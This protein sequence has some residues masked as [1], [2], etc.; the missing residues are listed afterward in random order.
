M[1]RS[2]LRDQ[3]LATGLPIV[4]DTRTQLNLLAKNR[5]HSLQCPVYYRLGCKS[6]KR[7]LRIAP[8]IIGVILNSSSLCQGY[9]GTTAYYGNRGS[10]RLAFQ[11]APING[12]LD[13]LKSDPPALGLCHP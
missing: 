2:E 11:A 6:K 12:G 7:P 3:S 13:S 8:L 10:K 1:V 9:V 4:L 5:E